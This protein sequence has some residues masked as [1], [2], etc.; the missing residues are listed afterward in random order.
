MLA[1]V[2]PSADAGLGCG[3]WLLGNPGPSVRGYVLM[4]GRRLCD[5]LL[6]TGVTSRVA[7]RF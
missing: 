5:D 3:F 7:R 2:L 1:A 6:T 4:T